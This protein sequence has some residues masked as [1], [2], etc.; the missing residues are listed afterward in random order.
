MSAAPKIVV[1][2][3]NTNGNDLEMEIATIATSAVLIDLNIS[4]WY[5]RKLDKG[6]SEEVVRDK[7]AGSKKAVSVVK[8]LMVDDEDLERIKSYGQAARMYFYHNTLPWSDGGT[9]LLP[10]KLIFEVTSE[11]EARQLQF[12]SYVNH[13]INNYTVKVSAQAFKQGQLF[14]R[15]EYPNADE[16]RRKFSFKYILYPVPTVGDFR[17]DVQK[18]TASFL[19]EQYKK[20][21]EDRVATMLRDPWE[22]A[23]E[24]LTH[25]RERMEVMLS[26]EPG[27]D[28][29]GIP[30]DGRKAPKL[31]QSVIDSAAELGN[32]LDKLNITN[33]PQLSDC[34]ARI[35]RAMSNLDVKVLRSDRTQQETLKKQVS[36]IISAFDFGGFGQ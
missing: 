10:T 12:E 13:L 26:Y 23:Y 24:K 9:R 21:A 30:P 19:K 1:N 8:H 28:A 15:D 3:V 32:L 11:L 2:N 6:T 29:L 22:R 35:R 33:D 36:D 7:Q 14:N 4:M 34:A 20:G 16:I 17:V 25:I 31:F 27:V 5:G 18:D